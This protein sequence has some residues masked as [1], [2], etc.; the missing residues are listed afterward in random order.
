MLSVT[1]ILFSG[2]ASSNTLNDQRNDFI[3]A[4]KL[5]E[6]KDDSNFLDLSTTL[7]DYPLYPYLQYQWLKNKLANTEKIVNFLSTYQDSRYAELL[8][9]KWLD[10]LA[11][12]Q[13]WQ[14]IVQFYQ[15]TDDTSGQCQYYW[16]HY[17]TGQQQAALNEARRLWSSGDDLPKECEQLLS[18][19]IASKLL[20]QDL[21]WQR[22]QLALNSD[23]AALATHVRSFLGDSQRQQA[24]IWLRV[25]KKPVLILESG[26]LSPQQ[27]ELFAHGIN[28]LAQS[29]LDLAINEWDGRK[30]LFSLNP[31]T[32]QKTERKLALALAKNRD[33]RAFE[34][35]DHLVL[36]DEDTR[37]WKIRSAL[38]EQNWEHVRTAL[39]DLTNEEQQ[40][41]KWQYWQARALFE[42]GDVLQAYIIANK[43][44]ED[45]SFYGFL[46]ADTVNKPYNSPDIPVKLEENTIAALANTTDFKVIQE[47]SFHKLDMEAQRQWWFAI[48]KLGKEQLLIA[49]KLAQY[50]QWDQVAIITLVKAD[51]WDDLGLRFPLRYL[52]EV[53]T[54]AQTRQLDPAIIL[55]LI[56]QESMLDN[57]AKSGS[58]ALGLMQLMPKTA[59]KIA[60]DLNENWQGEKSL[61]D[62]DLNIKY[63]SYYYK[64]LLNRFNNHFALATAAYN[65]GPNRAVKWLPT[66]NPVPADIWI[67]TI[68]YKETRKYVTAVLSYAII[69][70]QQMRTSSIKLKALLQ[71]VKPVGLPIDYY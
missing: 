24:E 45:R 26:F 29:D 9:S 12:Q 65:A 20:T 2:L 4:Q 30:Q 7:V 54:N 61:H 55:G 8:R 28:R 63:G 59:K 31:E 50:W 32:S 3:L 10:Y 44:A 39:T 42:S 17:K 25:H 33:Q 48:K 69:Y 43:L 21:I 14:E 19:L 56:R 40:Q 23:N 34:R 27:G 57:N 66:D 60:S 58:G 49:A 70:Q 41:P 67:E 37:E 5:L 68:P 71:D 1:L 38:L 53:K 22:F 62:S 16:A 11:S 64:Q 13:R 36:L 6:Q 52:T 15:P 51:Y 46:A 35:L 47:L 18:A